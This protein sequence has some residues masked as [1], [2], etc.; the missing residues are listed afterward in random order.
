MLAFGETTDDWNVEFANSRSYEKG[1]LNVLHWPQARVAPRMA[2]KD[3]EGAGIVYR[4]GNSQ[5]CLRKARV[6]SGSQKLDAL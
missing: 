6:C 5:L 4:S 2:S 3:E 1:P